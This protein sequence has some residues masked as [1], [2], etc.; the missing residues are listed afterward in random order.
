MIKM[1]RKTKK[2]DCGTQGC[3]ND[4]KRGY[5]MSNGTIWLCPECDTEI[6]GWAFTNLADAI[7]EIDLEG[8][9]FAEKICKILDG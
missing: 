4:A 2:K 9:A 7:H 1:T 8:R 5:S 3:Q 6:K